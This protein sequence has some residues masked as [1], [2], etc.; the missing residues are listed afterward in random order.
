MLALQFV[1]SIPAYAIVKAAGG[2]PDVATSALSMLK[3][4]DVAEPELPTRDWV[5]VMPTLSGV[6]GSDL[7]A[8]GG[9][10]SLYLDPLTSYPF[11]PGHEVVGTLDD[12]TRV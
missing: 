3:L 10:A 2:R 12:G 7:A 5:R 4:G 9:H 11:V 8:I 1:R 6:C